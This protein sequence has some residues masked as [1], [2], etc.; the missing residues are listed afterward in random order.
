MVEINFDQKL[1]RNVELVLQAFHTKPFEIFDVKMLLEYINKDAPMM[2]QRTAYRAVER[3][4]EMGRVTCNEIVK[5][6]RKYE[7]AEGNYCTLVC[8]RCGNRA[9]LE[10]KK[11]LKLYQKIYK[12]YGFD[13]RSAA[14]RI[15][16]KCS[17][18]C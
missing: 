8:G 2:S 1:T 14:M 4:V 11:D 9:H 6:T 16:G 10:I 3:L 15:Y 17:Y 5:G 18:S 13:V 7:L 12:D